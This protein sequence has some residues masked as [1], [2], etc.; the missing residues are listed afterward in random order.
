MMKLYID[1]DGV[2]LTKKNTKVSDGAEELIN[3]VTEKF[4]CYWLTTHCRNGST[5]SLLNMMSQYFSPPILT[6]LKRIKPIV[7]NTLKTEGI[8]FASEFYWIDDYVFEAEKE[9]LK[10]NNVFDKL[11]IVNLIGRPN[12]FD[13]LDI[14]SQK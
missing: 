14:I 10:R 11:I 6:K 3:Y 9:I 5:D 12:L 7:W 4:E 13:V 8:D 2:L 1:I